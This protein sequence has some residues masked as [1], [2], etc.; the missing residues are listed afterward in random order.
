M[1]SAKSFEDAS[2]VA[3]KFAQEHPD[4]L[5][6]SVADHET[7]GMTLDYKQGTPSVFHSFQATYETM[8]TDV[9]TAVA[10][11]GKGADATAIAGAV[12]GVVSEMTGGA[13][14]LTLDEIASVLGAATPEDAYAEFA[15][16]LN[17]RGGVK[18]T[19]GGHT[20]IDV[21]LYAYGPGADEINGVVD[22]TAV[23]QWL[24]KAMGLELPAN[25]QDDSG[26]DLVADVEHGC[27]H[28][29]PYDTDLLV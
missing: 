2:S 5:V 10:N 25:Q 3:L 27:H 19:T 24:A 7:G 15:A 14:T 26:G 23:G 12:N 13:A 21:P 18:Y 8:L 29:V 22:N 16:A 17:A 6:V 1:H 11:L 4:T 20:A 28:H 9:Q